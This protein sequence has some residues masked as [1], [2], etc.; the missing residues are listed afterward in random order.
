MASSVEQLLAF[1]V[2]D[3]DPARVSIA[4]EIATTQLQGSRAKWGVV[5][6]QAVALLA[7]HINWSSDPDNAVGET[8]SGGPVTSVGTDKLSIS[9]GPPQTNGATSVGDADLLRSTWGQ[10]F[11]RLRQ[12]RAGARATIVTV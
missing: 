8:G 7:A 10:Q 1:Y 3:M 12:S 2:P 9:F 5:Y 6:N 11:I 4:I